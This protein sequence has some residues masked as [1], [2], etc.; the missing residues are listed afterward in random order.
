MEQS[1]AKVNI[2]H[3]S[4]FMSLLLKSDIFCIRSMVYPLMM[5]RHYVGPLAY[6]AEMVR[7]K[8]LGQQLNQNGWIDNI[9]VHRFS[10]Q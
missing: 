9:L 7:Q 10:Q 3:T 8:T 6:P 2:T 5:V 4:Y 1:A